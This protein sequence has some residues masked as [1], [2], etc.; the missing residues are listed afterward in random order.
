M[1]ILKAMSTG[2]L[3]W[4]LVVTS[5]T[6]LENAPGFKDSLFRQGIAVM[7][8]IP[9]YSWLTA[10]LFYRRNSQMN[11]LLVGVFSSLTALS[12]DVMITVPL[13]EIPKGSS[14]QKF[15]TDPVLWVLAAENIVTFFLYWKLKVQPKYQAVN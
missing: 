4:L 1:K 2:I 9:F 14:Y 11:G 13:I 8:G 7:I 6:L 10:S 5:F 15:F 3:V 12:L